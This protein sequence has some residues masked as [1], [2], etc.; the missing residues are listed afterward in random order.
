M[1]EANVLTIPAGLKN[2]VSING[3]QTAF[4]YVDGSEMNWSQ[5]AAEIRTLSEKLQL[6]G[7]EKGDRVS[8]Y[9]PNMPNWALAYLAITGMGAV[10][11]PLLPD[12]SAEEVNNILEHSGA[13]LIFVSENLLSKLK[14]ISAVNLQ[15][16]INISDFSTVRSD[17]APESATAFIEY[18]VEE[19]DLA[20]I[21]YT[22]GT[23]GKSKGVML[24][25]KNIV[26]N[27]LAA[28]KV[29]PIVSTDRFLSV[30]PLSHT[31]E[32]TLGL[33]LP[34]LF[35]AAVYYMK[36]PPTPAVLLPALKTVRPTVMLTVPLIME[37]IYRNKIL[38][39]FNKN[40]VLKFLY[41]IPF[42]RKKLNRAAG[43]K[44]YQTFGGCLKFFGI[45]GA[46]LNAA[47][48][49]FLIEAEFPYAIGYGLTETSPL[50][51]GMAPGTYCHQSTGPAV[52]GIS[53]QI[54]NP[55]P[56]SGQGEIWAKGPNI[57]QGYYKE[58]ELT[59]E[60]LTPD[61][62]FK[63]GDV[64]VVDKNGFV[65]I[66]GRIKNVII[67][68]TGENIYPEDIESLINNFRHVV[69]SVVVEQKGKLVALVHFNVEEIE[70]RYQSMKEEVNDYAHKKVDE[71]SRELQDYINSR[72]S[73][74]SKIQAVVSH[75]VP[76][77]KT[78]T[79]KIKRFLYS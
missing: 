18:S 16:V 21:I 54:V 14:D 12:F 19:N 37:K 25:H 13:K 75:P 4:C 24:S 10:A 70:E 6:Y 65:F 53:L 51:A 68:S 27:A 57:M 11:V 38:P 67:G 62:W 69:E 7:I 33:I 43:K 44:L 2:S 66:K 63:T 49:Q 79:Q 3:N 26:S 45:G 60:V 41:S 50:L 15:T 39:A 59:A 34:M 31:Y 61:G 56:E 48:E 52:D 47:V 22:S 42:F 1:T 9:S 64:G 5:A 35:G 72:V 36:Q 40:G 32:N 8:I 77:H 78:A 55:D 58:P 76:F 23:T 20:A 71:L 29:Q 46:K 30:L 73:K 74:F 28:G 17:I